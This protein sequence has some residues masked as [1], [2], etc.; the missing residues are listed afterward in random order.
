[1]DLTELVNL[2]VEIAGNLRKDDR[3]SRVGKEYGISEVELVL[4]GPTSDYASDIIYS[5]TGRHGLKSLEDIADTFVDVLR[6]IYDWGNLAKRYDLLDIFINVRR[7]SGLVK[8]QLCER[9]EKE[10]SP[11]SN[12][13]EDPL[14][15]F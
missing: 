14:I 11:S 5:G 8:R 15:V 13:P 6:A 10:D 7:W 2:L 1:M 4:Q 9:R 12:F 3:V